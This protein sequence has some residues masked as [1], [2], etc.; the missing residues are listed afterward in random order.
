MT[1]TGRQLHILRRPTDWRRQQRFNS[2]WQLYRALT[3]ERDLIS[4]AMPGTPLCVWSPRPS[5]P[6]QRS[7][8]TD[9]TKA[10]RH[11][12]TSVGHLSNSSDNAVLS[13]CLSAC[14]AVLPSACACVCACECERNWSAATR[15]SGPA[16]R[17]K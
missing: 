1:E 10:S 6:V 5:N 17:S 4:Q 12:L 11:D 14:V 8:P 9:L 2:R 3:R 13:L 15:R 7:A 16:M